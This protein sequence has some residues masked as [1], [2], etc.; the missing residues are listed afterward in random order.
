MPVWRLASDPI[1]PERHRSREKAQPFAPHFS[2]FLEV[3][4]N[5]L[6]CKASPVVEQDKAGG[7][8]VALLRFDEK[9][10]RRCP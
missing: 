10:K 9:T 3:A 6:Q 2:H 5:R 4:G 8:K 1:N 7:G